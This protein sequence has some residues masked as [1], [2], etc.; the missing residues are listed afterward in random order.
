MFLG[1]QVRILPIHVR[2]LT[3]WTNVKLWLAMA[4]NT[5]LHL[6][7]VFLINGRHLIDP[8]VTTR[9]AN[10]LVHVYAVVEVNKFGQVVN[11]LPLDGFVLSKARSYRLQIW[12]VIPQLA[13]TVH[14][15][16]CGWHASSCRRLNSGM[17]ITAI[18]AVVTDVVL[19][20][21]LDRLLFFQ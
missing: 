5:P 10:A 3:L 8:A 7:S 21:E 17:A 4:G 16:L 20:A 19:V 9:T 11:S 2:D 18:D 6:Q 14:T 12:A 13:V 15:S 1:R